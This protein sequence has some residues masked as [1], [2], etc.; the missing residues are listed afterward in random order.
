MKFIYFKFLFSSFL[1]KTF[2]AYYRLPRQLRIITG[3]L[4]AGII[5]LAGGLPGFFIGIVL[6]YL[7]LELAGQFKSDRA[8]IDYYNNPGASGFYEGE[9]G[10]AAFCGLAVLTVSKSLQDPGKMDL[11]IDEISRSIKMYFPAAGTDISIADHFCRIAFSELK[12]LNQDLLL[13]SLLARRKNFGDSRLLG[14]LLYNLASSNEA[15]SF[16]D[17]IRKKIDPHYRPVPVSDDP[18]KIL[19]I[20]PETPFAE[21]KSHYRMLAAQ[22][23]PDVLS[24]L[25]EERRETAARAFI[26][27][28]EAYREIT[29]KIRQ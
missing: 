14:M 20:S 18:Y 19:D 29:E 4:L 9:P 7:I 5:G 22:F 25:D 11:T 27:I 16:A 23:H 28:Q 8:L 21:I 24:E 13:E 15:R 1:K 17:E 10:L 2:R 3:L 26:A 6:G 12:N